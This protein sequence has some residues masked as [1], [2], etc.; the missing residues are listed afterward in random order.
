MNG[1]WLLLVDTVFLQSGFACSVE[2]ERRVGP[3]Q[4]AT[5]GDEVGLL[6]VTC[7]AGNPV[8][9]PKLSISNGP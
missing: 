6:C 7:P 1:Q 9:L 5:D 3:G 8:Q 2:S 4:C